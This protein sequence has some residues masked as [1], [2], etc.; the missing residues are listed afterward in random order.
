MTYKNNFVVAIKCNGK[1][2]RESNGVV[3]LPFGSEYS[4]YMKN[5]A[6]TKALVGVTVDGED[7]LEGKKLIIDPNE[8]MDLERALK[9]SMSSGY[10]FKFIEKTKEI[11]EHRGDHIDDGIVRVEFAFEIPEVH[12]HTIPIKKIVEEH[13]HH[14][15]HHDDWWYPKTWYTTI[16]DN[17]DGTTLSYSSSCNFSN[18]GGGVQAFAQSM[19]NKND[20]GI[21][22]EGS[23]S[24][25]SF[26]YGHI[27][28]VGPSEVIVF[29]LRGSAVDS[30]PVVKAVTVKDKL[31]C[32]YC[33]RT[34]KSS[35][36][37]CPGCGARLIG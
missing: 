23:D 12:F 3:Y 11:S 16:S 22:V 10:R 8:R 21:T 29:E 17:L 28:R 35:S 6:A 18:T 5:L 34:S 4:I 30:T 26:Y 31:K 19:P 9:G 7:I 20:K 2:L 37:Y 32:N 13:H 1:I 14:H 24:D 36:Q 15:H 27:G 25:Q 33:G